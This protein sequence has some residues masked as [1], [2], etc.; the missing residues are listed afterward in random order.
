MFYFKSVM[1][2]AGAVLQGTHPRVV[3]SAIEAAELRQDGCE[4]TGGSPMAKR[5]ELP[6]PLKATD[7]SPS[8][9][10]SDFPK[11]TLEEALRVA[12][13]IEDANGGRAYPPNDTAIALNMSPGSSAWRTLSA[14]SFKYGL[15]SGTYKS[16]RLALTPLGL[17]VVEPTSSEDRMAALFSAALIPPTFSRVFDAFRSKKI[18]PLNFFQNTLSREFDVPKEQASLCG[19]IFVN[20]AEFVGAV[21]TT[22]SGQW[23]GDAPSGQLPGVEDTSDADLDEVDD[24]E[25]PDVEED[26]LDSPATKSKDKRSGGNAVFLG[27]GK[28]KKPM[29]QLQKILAEYGVPF[30]VAIDEA[31]KGRPISEKVAGVM[32]ECGAAILIFT[33]DEEF[34][35]LAGLEVWR[36]SE[37]VVYELGACSI[38]YGK[39][40]IVFKEVGVTFPSNFRDIGYIEFDKDSLSAKGI[41]LFRELIAFNIIQVT[42]PSSA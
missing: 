37:N 18:P 36:P 27:H 31:N 38:L 3:R 33:A 16:E 8:R 17:R 14:A 41:D 10:R 13:A 4:L 32:S 2:F 11:H 26:A 29:E 15:T 9:A 19:S 34:R 1:Q 40:I 39:R 20:N 23:L 6:N 24:D 35:D 22:K 30:K 42:V 7:D 12:K 21:R 25:S 28:N 5:G